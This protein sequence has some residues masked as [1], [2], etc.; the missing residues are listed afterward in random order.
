MAAWGK[1]SEDFSTK[2]PGRLY[3]LDLVTGT[4]HDVSKVPL[5][6]LDGVA[7][8]SGGGWLVTDWVAGKL[9]RVSDP[10]GDAELLVEGIPGA[11]DLGYDP[12]RRLIVVPSSKAD[13]LE[14][15]NQD[16]LPR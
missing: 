14:G 4:R 7:P 1:P 8:A 9:W 13:Y 16:K 2:V 12:R 15:L 6:N 3:W 11:A 5:G 10:K